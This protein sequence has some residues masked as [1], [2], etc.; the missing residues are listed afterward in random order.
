MATITLSAGDMGGR[1]VETS[2]PVGGFV[3]VVSDS[4]ESAGQT[5]LYRVEPTGQ[6]TYCGVAPAAPVAAS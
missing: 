1:T 6:A 5:L 4:G 2:V 3:A